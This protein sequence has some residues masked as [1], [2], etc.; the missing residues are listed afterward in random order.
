MSEATP[1]NVSHVHPLHPQNQNGKIHKYR[2]ITTDTQIQIIQILKYTIN[3]VHDPSLPVT[4]ASFASS[5]SFSLF[6][7]LRNTHIQ[8]GGGID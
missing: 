4:H 8:I 1:A 2:H 6:S 5:F 3:A 7:E